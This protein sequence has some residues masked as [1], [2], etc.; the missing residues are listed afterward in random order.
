MDF[1][2]FKESSFDVSLHFIGFCEF[3]IHVNSF[4]VVD[5]ANFL[6]IVDLFVVFKQL[7]NDFFV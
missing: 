2:F 7:G 4:E 1:E 3:A 6:S 5:D